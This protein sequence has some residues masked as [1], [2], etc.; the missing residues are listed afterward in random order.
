MQFTRLS[1]L[2]SLIA[3]PEITPLEEAK[4]QSSDFEGISSVVHD[5]LADLSDK[6]EALMSLAKETGAMKLDTVKDKDGM[7]VFKKLDKCTK[8]YIKEMKKLMMEAEAMVM[9][10]AEGTEAAD[11]K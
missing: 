2:T 5:A 3:Q 7:T 6:M 8:D 10:V 11:V 4:S 9:Q 1:D